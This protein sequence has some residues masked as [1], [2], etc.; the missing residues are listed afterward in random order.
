MSLIV[1]CTVWL[2]GST[3]DADVSEDL[4]EQMILT[5]RMCSPKR[6]QLHAHVTCAI[7]TKVMG[8]VLNSSK[9]HYVYSSHQY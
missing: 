1:S 7:D 2:R 5:H 3:F 8:A 6:R 4:R 9:P